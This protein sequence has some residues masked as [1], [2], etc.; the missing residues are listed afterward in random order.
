MVKQN[1]AQKEEFLQL[2]T[3]VYFTKTR[4]E[5][6]EKYVDLC[7]DKACFSVIQL[8][9][10]HLLRYLT[11][12]AIVNKNLHKN[13]NYSFDLYKLTEIIKRGVVKYSDPFTQFIENLYL[14]FDFES[15]A[16]NIRE[17]NEVINGDVLLL[18][19]RDRIIESCQ[20]LYFKVY[21]KI[22]ESVKIEEI[23]KFIKKSEFEAEL[24]I[25]KYI[26][27][28]DIEAKIDSIEGRVVS[29]RNKEN[30]AERYINAIPNI[31]TLISTMTTTSHSEHQ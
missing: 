9:S 3:L 21:C 6:L 22:Y 18:Q 24:W 14:N 1:Y 11:V 12:A 29:M 27:S 17:I 25:L 15:A 7:N 4:D 16:D 13:R 26:R 20:F 28:S 2:V 10:P 5:D 19:L 8:L 23:S 30:R 31:N